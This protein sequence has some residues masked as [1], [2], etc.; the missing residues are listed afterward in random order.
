MERSAVTSLLRSALDLH[1]VVL[2]PAAT[3]QKIA[4]IFS[5]AVVSGQDD[6]SVQKTAASPLPKNENESSSGSSPVIVPCCWGQYR[7]KWAD[8]SDNEET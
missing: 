7:G 4:D 8:M 2:G 3:R 1:M 6:S 5:A